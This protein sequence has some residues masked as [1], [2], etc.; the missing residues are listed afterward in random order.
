MCLSRTSSCSAVLFLEVFAFL[1]FFES[2]SKLEGS[3]SIMK[4]ALRFYNGNRSPFC[5]YKQTQA[6]TSQ[7]SLILALF[8]SL[9]NLQNE[10]FTI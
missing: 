3:L 2:L 5:S 10:C 7:N 9:I 6:K 8:A 4:H 1:L